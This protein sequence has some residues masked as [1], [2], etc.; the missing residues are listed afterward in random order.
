MVFKDL[1]KK[2][3]YW[4]KHFPSTPRCSL[5]GEQ[6]LSFT[7]YIFI[8][9]FW[10][11]LFLNSCKESKK[12]ENLTNFSAPSHFPA[13]IYPFSSTSF[14]EKKFELG[15]MLFYDPI[16]SKDSTVACAHC[17][18]QRY[19]FADGGKALSEGVQGRKG[20]RNAS[21]IFNLAWQSLFFADGGVKQ[22]HIHLRQR[23]SFDLYHLSWYR[24]SQILPL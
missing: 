13:P 7:C 16:L 1:I 2:K 23:E 17:H 21:P 9:L 14:T 10:G 12:N 11:I 4:K 8:T 18:Q 6:S 15:K 5:L 19:A 22:T 24:F 3:G 20:K